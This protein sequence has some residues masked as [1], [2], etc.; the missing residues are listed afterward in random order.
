[1]PFSTDAAGPINCD[2]CYGTLT[3]GDVLLNT[4]AWC[5]PDMSPLWGVPELRGQNRLIPGV[6]GRKAYKR[7]LDEHTVA[8]PF[9][10]TGYCN[11]DGIPY[12]DLGLSTDQG[13]EANVA[14]L[15][16]NVF[17]PDVD[18]ADDSTR[19]ATF[20]LPS[21]NVRESNV[22]VTLTSP[23]LRPGSMMRATIELT[24]VDALL[25]VGGD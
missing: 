17:N 15:Y 22:Q 12:R 8:L 5:I 4:D 6:Q 1:M 18:G 24:D 3:V 20:V 10:I 13:L 19:L 23:A 11:V 21:G 16:N 14:F 2:P 7:R 9:L 25:I